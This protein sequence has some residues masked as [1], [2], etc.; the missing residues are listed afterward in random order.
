MGY[1]H[2]YLVK[3]E[4]KLSTMADYYITIHSEVPGTVQGA[5]FGRGQFLCEGS[6][7]LSRP[8]VF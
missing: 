5:C 7:P 4:R 6:F 3:S 8:I 1:H 2:L